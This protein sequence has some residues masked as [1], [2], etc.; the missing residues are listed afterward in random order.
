MGINIK[1]RSDIS[2]LFSGMNGGI[3]GGTGGRWLSDYASIKNG[4]YGKLMKAYYGKNSNASIN[5][6]A[7]NQVKYPGKESEE[8]KQVAKIRTT[9]DSL[10]ET[11]DRLLDKKL[12]ASQDMDGVYKAVS[13]FTAAYN[14]VIEAVGRT[15]DSNLQRRGESLLNLS[16]SNLKALKGIGISVEED[17]TLSVNQESFMKADPTKIK[18]VLQ[19]AGSYGYQVS[20]QAS[21]LNFAA[22]RAASRKSSYNINGSFNN[23]FSN[24]NLF[25]SYF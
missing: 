14:S 11:A 20:A 2:Y 19:T 9:S 18:G 8:T 4:S 23:A 21:L 22:E 13:D 10:K 16:I 3:T 6:L 5:R 25:N 24:G 7:Q 12:Y 17:G 1:S 15:E